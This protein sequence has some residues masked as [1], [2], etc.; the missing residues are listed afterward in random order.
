MNSFDELPWHDATLV[1]VLI[2]RRAP[3]HDDRIVLAI[4]WPS[5]SRDFIE[6]QECSMFDAHMNFGMIVPDHARSAVA[7]DIDDGLERLRQT[8]SKSGVQMPQLKCYQIELN[9]TAG[10]LRTY[11]AGFTVRTR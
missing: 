10:V 2:D 6:F 5:G 11:A 4:D 8:W 9:S 3:G 1:D 7:L